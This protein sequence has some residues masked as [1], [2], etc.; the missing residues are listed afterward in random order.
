MR[1]QKARRYL[2]TVARLQ[3]PGLYRAARKDV[4]ELAVALAEE[5]VSAGPN[6]AQLAH[7]HLR[8]LAIDRRRKSMYI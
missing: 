1:E 3:Y 8:F 6:R 2:L 4:E 5:L 7:K